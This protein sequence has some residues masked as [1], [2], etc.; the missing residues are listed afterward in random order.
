MKTKFALKAGFAALALAAAGASN[1]GLFYLDI[2]TA[3]GPTG[4]QVT[5]TS[6]SMKNEIQYKYDSKTDIV[7]L[8]APGISA[9]DTLTTTA[10]LAVNGITIAN[11]LAGNNSINNF[12]PSQVFTN[13]SNNGYGA[14]WNIGFSATGLN[15][16]VTGVIGGVPTFQYAPAGQIQLYLSTDGLTMTNFMNINVTGGGATGVST[17]L[18]GEVD[19]TGITASAAMKNLFHSGTYT[20]NGS[21][22]FFDIW[23]NCDTSAIKFAST[24][25][26][27]VR[28][29]QFTPTATGFTITSNH[30]GSATF[31]IPEPGSLALLGLGL[32]G[33]GLV[34]RRRNLAK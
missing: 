27:N 14:N 34:K 12:L 15:G 3:F 5:S 23:T 18:N 17:I 2:G 10:G 4:G 9:G 1:A 7:D 26:T 33:L 16:V 25:D 8:G 13:N 11:L 21:S 22:G 20:C 32:A 6:T 28:S 24:Q 29:A 19:F 31:D 30:N